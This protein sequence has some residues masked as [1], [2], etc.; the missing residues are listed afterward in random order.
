MDAAWY[1]IDTMGELNPEWCMLDSPPE[2]IGIDYFMMATGER[3]GDAYPSDARIRM[4]GER[5]GI[6][7]GALI[8]NTLSYL[9]VHRE[10]VDVTRPFC[11][12]IDVE[13]LPFTLINHKGRVHSDAYLIVNPI[14]TESVLDLDLSEIL[15]FEMPGD[16][17]DGEIIS[18]D[19]PV[20]DPEKAAQAP[21]L[22][23]LAE[24][25]DRIVASA[26]LRAALQDGDFENLY[27]IPLD[28]AE[29][30]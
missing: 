30:T 8:G 11:A 7:L 14:G 24:S 18:L 3:I 5:E 22:F 28:V 1:F 2:E 26:D 12:E 6:R 21:P 23:R 29:T 15:Y 17:Y 27:F 20:I 4:S 16:P 19:N 10:V 25:P 13:Y 9:I